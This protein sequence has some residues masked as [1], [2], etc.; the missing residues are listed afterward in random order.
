[1]F[2]AFV[3]GIPSFLDQEIPLVLLVIEIQLKAKCLGGEP[4]MGTEAPP[5][6]GNIPFIYTVFNKLHL[7]QLKRSYK[8]SNKSSNEKVQLELVNKQRL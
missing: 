3:S 5:S 8:L 7:V 1:M 4:P 6:T 2:W